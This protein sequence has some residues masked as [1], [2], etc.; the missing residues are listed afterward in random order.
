LIFILYIS[1]AFSCSNKNI[2]YNYLIGDFNNCLKPKTN[3]YK[4]EYIRALCYIGSEKHDEARYILSNLIT[5]LD[6]EDSLLYLVLNSLVEINY[7]IGEYEKA[8]KLSIDSYSYCHNKL[9]YSCSISSILKIKALYSE[10][11][12]NNALK[13]YSSIEKTNDSFFYYSLKIN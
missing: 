13:L 9:S 7:I 4:C 2:N 12:F 10:K 6:K 3:I 1:L 5:K 11:D 8:Y